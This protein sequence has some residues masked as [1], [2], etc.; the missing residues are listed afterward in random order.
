LAATLGVLLGIPVLRLRG[1]YSHR[2]ARC[3]EIHPGDC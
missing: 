1:D 3:G 2:A